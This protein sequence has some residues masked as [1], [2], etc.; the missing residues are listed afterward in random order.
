[1]ADRDISVEGIEVE[2]CDASTDGEA[3]M[4]S[5]TAAAP[6]D[7][8]IAVSQ[9]GVDG[10]PPS[11]FKAVVTEA[12]AWL[13]PR[14]DSLNKVGP[15][16]HGAMESPGLVSTAGAMEAREHVAFWVGFHCLHR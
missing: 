5:A 13:S 3:E 15:C 10:T 9:V 2:V 16:T 1:M 6:H 8:S 7:A 4:S 14:G 12:Q 11:V